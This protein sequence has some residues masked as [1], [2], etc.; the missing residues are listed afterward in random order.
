LA[1]ETQILGF[2]MNNFRQSI[3]AEDQAK[4]AKAKKEAEAISGF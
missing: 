2:H 3:E 4:K 1:D